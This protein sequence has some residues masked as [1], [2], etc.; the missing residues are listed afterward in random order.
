MEYQIGAIVDCRDEVQDWY[1]STVMNMTD[2][3]YFIHFNQWSERF[4]CWI[5]KVH[6]YTFT[7]VH[8]YNIYTLSIDIT[9]VYNITLVCVCIEWLCKI[10]KQREIYKWSKI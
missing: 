10:S 1:E 4:D 9:F 3:Q 2:D 6:I 8:I 5:N 7:H